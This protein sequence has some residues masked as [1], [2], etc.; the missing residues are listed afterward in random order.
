VFKGIKNEIKN[1]L[2][3]NAVEPNSGRGRSVDERASPTTTT[4]VDSWPCSVV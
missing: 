1:A 3:D 2:S 4:D